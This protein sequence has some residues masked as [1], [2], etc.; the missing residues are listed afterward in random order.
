MQPSTTDV[1]NSVEDEAVTDGQAGVIQTIKSVGTNGTY[2]FIVLYSTVDFVLLAGLSVFGVKYFQ[3][4][5]GL[6][7]SLAGISVGTS[8]T[9]YTAVALAHLSNGT[10][11]FKR[12]FVYNGDY[13]CVIE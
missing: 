7:T 1:D 5:F 6:T 2:V 12:F 11:R 10:V 3:Q 8:M 13:L 4:Q 9:I